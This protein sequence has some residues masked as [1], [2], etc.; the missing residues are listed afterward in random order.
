MIGQG[1]ATLAVW[2]AV[3]VAA[4]HEP[5]TV[6]LTLPFAVIATVSIWDQTK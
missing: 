6:I 5:T 4:M 2:G 1:I 3:A